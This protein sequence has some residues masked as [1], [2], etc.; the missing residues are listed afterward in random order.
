MLVLAS[1]SPRRKELLAQAGFTFRVHASSIPENHQ[2]GEDAIAFATR[3]AREKAQ[4]VFH[5]LRALDSGNDPLLVLG[6]DTIVVSP[7][8]EILGKPKD[9]N[10]A[11]RML[12]Q[13]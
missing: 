1:A 7:A 9:A 3:L 12:R 10:D 8:K 13:L 5:E 2:D 6:A 11:T 4:A